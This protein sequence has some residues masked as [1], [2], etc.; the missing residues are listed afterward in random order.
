MA[1]IHHQTLSSALRI[2]VEPLVDVTCK[3]N[4]NAGEPKGPI[5]EYFSNSILRYTV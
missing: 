5:D 1:T 2:V 3:S 4:G